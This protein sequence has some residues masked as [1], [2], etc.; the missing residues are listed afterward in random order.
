[1]PVFSRKVLN[2]RQINPDLK[3]ERV[4]N[5]E[6]VGADY[7]KIIKIINIYPY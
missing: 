6:D 4:Q 7:A 2:N 5:M 1:L 3:G